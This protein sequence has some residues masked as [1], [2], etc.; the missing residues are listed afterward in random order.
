[1]STKCINVN[2]IIVYQVPG[3]YIRAACRVE[4][5]SSSPSS[6][7]SKPNKFTLFPPNDFMGELTR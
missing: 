3:G 5:A 2:I 7:E 1:M 4:A 6:V